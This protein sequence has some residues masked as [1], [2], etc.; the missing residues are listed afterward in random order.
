VGL[1][2]RAADKVITLEAAVIALKPT[3]S[4]PWTTFSCISMHASPNAN[5]S[6]L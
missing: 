3:V 5:A 6:T 1:F 4:P 2:K